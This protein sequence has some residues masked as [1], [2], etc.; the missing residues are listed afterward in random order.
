VV[1]VYTNNGTG[2]LPSAA[3]ESGTN[4]YAEVRFVAAK[5]VSYL[6]AVAGAEGECGPVVLNRTFAPAPVIDDPTPPPPPNILGT[7][8]RTVGSVRTL[9]LTFTAKQGVTYEVLTA[10]R[11]ATN[12]VWSS[13]SPAVTGVVTEEVEIFALEVPMTN[14]AAFFKVVATAW[15]GGDPVEPPVRPANDNWAEASEFSNTV[16]SV[17]GD[18][19]WATAEDGE[20]AHGGFAD[21]TNSVWWS[22]TAP[23]NGVALFET[24]S[25]GLAW[26]VVAVYTN[27]G[28]GGRAPVAASE[29]GSN[30]VAQV[31]VPVVSGATYL[32][33]VA[34]RE[35]TGGPVTLNLTFEPEKQ[36][37]PPP[38]NILGT[39]TRMAEGVR[40]LTLTFTAKQGAT[41]EVLTTPRL[42]TNA[43]WSS[44]APPVAG[45]VTEAVEL[46]AL[47]VPMT[48]AAAFFKI[49]AR[50]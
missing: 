44:L 35:G 8:V 38:P 15:S 14:A 21:A 17:T 24:Q 46:F 7:A 47:D 4:G 32:I 39:A 25:G 31:S 33:A 28:V 26:P 13:L 11:L 10:P 23:S 18:S 30:G 43:V 22:W 34:G 9:S 36:V 29:S 2:W 6:I 20:P 3:S 27:S 16:F 42:V 45:V 49:E 12:A 50:R 1:A 5:S 48:N 41:Y 19:T 37:E 40:M